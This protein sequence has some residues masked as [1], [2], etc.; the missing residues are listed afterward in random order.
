[1]NKLWV[2][3][4][5]PGHADYI[6]PIAKKKIYE[7]DIVIASKRQLESIESKG[8]KVGLQIP[9]VNNLPLLE[10]Y[11]DKQIAVIVS[12]D[13]CF[14]SMLTFLKKHFTEIVCFPG[15][16]SLQ[17]LFTKLNLSYEKAYLGSAHGREMDQG[18]L[19]SYSLF[20]ILTDRVHNPEEIRKVF[21]RKGT[22][23]VGE[24]LS[25]DDERIRSYALDEVIHD[26][27]NDLCVVVIKYD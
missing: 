6:L 3:G 11:R 13:P 20:G 17:Y 7:A 21:H 14:Y 16:S 10:T 8:E 18:L 1:M 15:I 4:L 25:Y 27:F 24:R 9:L 2:V 23:Y 22:M 5:G 19:D 12:G 26:T